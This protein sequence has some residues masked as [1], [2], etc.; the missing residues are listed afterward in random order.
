MSKPKILFLDCETRPALAYVWRLHDENVGLEQLIEPSNILSVGWK[1]AGRRPVQYAD[2][3]P[4]RDPKSRLAMLQSAWEALHVADAVVTFNGDRFDLPKLTGEFLVAGLPPTP[5]IA[6]IDLYKT[7][8]K[9]GF[10]SGKLAHAG[11][12]LGCGDKI[13]TGGFKLWKDYMDGDPK[14]RAS[15]KKYNRQDVVLLEKVYQRVRPYITGHAYIRSETGTCPACGSTDIQHRGTRPTRAFR[16]ERLN[17]LN[18][19]H[20]FPGKRSKV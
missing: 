16:V 18:C 15:M 14:A 6:S 3:W 10:T 12:L 19:G 4:V 1:W 5:P 9:M 11:P 17:C 7:I 20:W 13:H 8:K 2:V